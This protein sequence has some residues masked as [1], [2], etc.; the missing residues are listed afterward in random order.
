MQ[1]QVLIVDDSLTVRMDSRASLRRGGLR[2]RPLRR[3]EAAR[4]ALENGP[5]ALAVLDVLLPDGDGIDYLQELKQNAATAGLPVLILSTE[6]EAKDRIRGLS[7][8]A[9]DFV[10]KPYDRDYMIQRAHELLPALFPSAAR[11]PS[12]R[13]SWSS[14]TAFRSAR[15]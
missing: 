9:D 10:G 5:F 13:W 7:I 12:R 1:P 14:M 11:G 8:G 2:H 4:L 6:A 3:P 15:S